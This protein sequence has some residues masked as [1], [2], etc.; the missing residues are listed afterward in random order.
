[1]QFRSTIWG[2]VILGFWKWKQYFFADSERVKSVEEQKG[3]G[4]RCSENVFS[5]IRWIIWISAPR[6]LQF[7]LCLC[8]ERAVIA[9]HLIFRLAIDFQIYL[10]LF[11]DHG[12]GFWV[13]STKNNIFGG[14]VFVTS[15]HTGGLLF[16]WT[17]TT[18]SCG[19]RSLIVNCIR[20][21]GREGGGA[22]SQIC[23]MRN[24]CSWHEFLSLFPVFFRVRIIWFSLAFEESDW[25]RA[26]NGNN[27]L[28]WTI[29]YNMI[30]KS[31]Q[32]RKERTGS[33]IWPGDLERGMLGGGKIWLFLSRY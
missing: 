28:G 19:S 6:R 30:W 33:V 25:L 16:E 26:L 18:V 29:H 24:E 20:R 2:C 8:I 12:L 27:V 23:T 15:C 9:L 5:K 21:W 4:W 32:G 10:F 31:G 1:M 11:C 7:I 14:W 13:N 22:R 17:N 3:V